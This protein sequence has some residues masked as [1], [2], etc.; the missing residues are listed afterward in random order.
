[1]TTEIF[2]Y[3]VGVSGLSVMC[4]REKKRQFVWKS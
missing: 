4:S 1:M 3:Q 2:S